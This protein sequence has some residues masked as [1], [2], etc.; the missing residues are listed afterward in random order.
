MNLYNEFHESWHPVLDV[1]EKKLLKM[2]NKP[3]TNY[4]PREYIFRVFSMPLENIKVLI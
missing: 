2:I 3:G 4:P 1:W